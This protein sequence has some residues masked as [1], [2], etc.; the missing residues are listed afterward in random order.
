[1]YVENVISYNQIN[2]Q[3]LVSRLVQTQKQ[4]SGRKEPYSYVCV[5]NVG[6]EVDSRKVVKLWGRVLFK[7]KIT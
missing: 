5:Y 6:I 7:R 2:L 3:I 1:M 4:T